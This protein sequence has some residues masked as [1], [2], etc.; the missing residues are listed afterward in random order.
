M[1]NTDFPGIIIFNMMRCVDFS[2][3][4]VSIHKDF[5][6]PSQYALPWGVNPLSVKVFRSCS[7]P[8][9]FA[10]YFFYVSVFCQ[11]SGFRKNSLEPV[12]K[13]FRFYKFKEN[14]NCKLKMYLQSTDPLHSR[15]T[16]KHRCPTLEY[17]ELSPELSVC[18]PLFY[19]IVA[20]S[21]KD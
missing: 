9:G 6:L 10:F 4:G 11:K 5:S 14:E 1:S 16:G 7:I 3:R 21:G 8:M 19:C 13:R 2:S 17:L 15:K 12:A 18:W 20:R